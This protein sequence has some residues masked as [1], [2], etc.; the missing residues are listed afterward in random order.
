VRFPWSRRGETPVALQADRPD[1]AFDLSAPAQ[2]MQLWGIGTGD[3]TQPVSRAQA[4]SVPAVKKARDLIAGSVGG[5]PVRVQNET[6]RERLPLLP[7]LLAQPEAHLARSVSMVKTVE[8]ML[9]EGRS[10]WRITEFDPKT[11]YPTKVRRLDH[12]LVRENQR[13][14]AARDGSVQGDTLEQVPDELLI[15]IES[16]T[17]GWLTAGARVIR[18]ALL[19]DK[20]AARIAA[21]PRPQGVFTPKEGVDPGD[22]DEIQ[23][24]LDAWNADRSENSWAYVGAALDLSP[25]SWTAEQIQLADSRQ[26]AVLEIARLTGLDAEDLGVSTTSRTYQNSEQRRLDRITDVLSPYISAIADRLSMDDVLPPGRVVRFDFTGFLRADSKTRMESF[27]IG[28]RVGAFDDE[29][30]AEV[31]DIPTSRVKAEKPAPAPMP[32]VRENADA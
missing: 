14:Y 7:P 12:V 28:R 1:A 30:I 23:E 27:E 11:N 4:M 19:L 2:L 16:P 9:F 29:R 26:H 24:M 6:T 21:S 3:Y 25:L 17:D 22:H 31:E 8:D 18:Q 13:V 5:L 20:I 10:W 15:R 32:A